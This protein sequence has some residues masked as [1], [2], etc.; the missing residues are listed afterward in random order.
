AFS[1]TIPDSGRRRPK[2]VKIHHCP[3]SLKLEAAGGTSQ[4]MSFSEWLYEGLSKSKVA[5]SD[6]HDPWWKVMCLTGV[7]YFSSMGFQPGISFLA[8]GFLSPLAT[9]NLVLLTLFG[10]LPAYWLVA[11]ESP[12]GQ[13]SFAIFERLLSGWKGKALVL[14]LLG[15]AATDFIFTITMCAA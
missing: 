11:K 9:L 3:A 4:D 2:E 13:G 15:F 10:A 6:H 12:H 1:S 8:A 7:D 14:V 5:V